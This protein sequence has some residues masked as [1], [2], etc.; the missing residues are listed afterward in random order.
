MASTTTSGPTSSPGTAPSVPVRAWRSLGTALA[1]FTVGLVGTP[2]GI[3]I[4]LVHAVAVG[5]TASSLVGL[6]ILATTLPALLFGGAG[7]IARLPGWWRLG[8]IPLLL[9]LVSVVLL[10]ATVAVAATNR[11]PTAL[12]RETPADRGLA[13]EDV[14]FTTAD[15]VRLA[16]WWVPGTDPSAVVLL[17]GSGETRSDVLDHL[18]T[19]SSLGH[20][21][22]AFDARGHGE[23]GGRAMDLGWFGDLDVRGAVDHLSGRSDVD[24]DRIAI[25]GLSMGGEEALG[26]A[27]SDPR[28]RAVVGEGVTARQNRDRGYLPG[29]PGRYVALAGGWVQDRIAAVLSG[30]AAP[31]PLPDAVVAMAPRPLLLIAAAGIGD[32]ERAAASLAAQRPSGVEVWVV[33]GSGHTGGRRTAPEEWAQ[34]VGRFLADAL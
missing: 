25:V 9:L 5:P 29:H 8:A 15:G 14:T 32:E 13:Y 20:G 33:E 16:G 30:T 7:L 24:P 10:P 22:L 26:A 17:H 3:G 11:A 12:G 23:S 28:L 2:I 18:A 21:V 6:L 31:T 4:G 19:L 1:L 27:A 34:R